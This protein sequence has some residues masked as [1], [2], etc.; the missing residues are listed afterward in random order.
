M[1]VTKDLVWLLRHGE[2]CGTR[3]P[4]TAALADESFAPAAPEVPIAARSTYRAIDRDA[5]GVRLRA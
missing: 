3:V 4:T 5:S 2:A 1:V